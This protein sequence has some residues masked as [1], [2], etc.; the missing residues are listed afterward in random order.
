MMGYR[1][2]W[3]ARIDRFATELDRRGRTRAKNKEEEK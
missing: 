2:M 1:A 3:E